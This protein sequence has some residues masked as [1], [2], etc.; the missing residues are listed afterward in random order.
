MTN[1]LKLLQILPESQIV[2][3]DRNAARDLIEELSSDYDDLAEAL[4]LAQ[5]ETDTNLRY[6]VIKV[7]EGEL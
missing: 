5:G 3:L 6:V 4:D 7:N 1:N 2:E